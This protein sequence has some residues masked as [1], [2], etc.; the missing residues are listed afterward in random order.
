M[1]TIAKLV[2]ELVADVSGFTSNMNSA[3]GVMESVSAGTVAMGTVMGNVATGALEFIAGAAVG[4]ARGGFDIL[5]DSI[6]TAMSEA[7][8][9]QD[10][11][12]DL[13]AVL[14][15]TGAAAAQQAQ[16]WADAQGQMV[17]V[18]GLSQEMTNKLLLQQRQLENQIAGSTEG[19]AKMTAEYG[20]D[21]TVVMENALRLQVL[22]DQLAAVNQQLAD[23]TPRTVALTDALGLT[24]PTARMTRDELLAMAQNLRDL[25]GGSDDAVIGVEAILLRFD[26]IG[27]DTFPQATETALD[28]AAALKIDR[29]SAATLLGKVLQ[30]GEGL[31]VLKQAGVALTDQ[32][33]K[34][35]EHLFAVGKAAEA[36][37]IIMQALAGTIGGTAAEKADTLSGR[38]EILKNHLL[39]TAEGAGM[40]L[41]PLAEKLLTKG[42]PYLEKFAEG[43][44]GIFDSPQFVA[45]MDFA[46]KTMDKFF[47]LLGE[48]VSPVDAFR[49]TLISIAPPELAGTINSIFSTVQGGVAL[50][51][52]LASGD[53]SPLTNLIPPGIQEQIGPLATAVQGLFDAVIASGPQFAAAGAQIGSVFQTIVSL[54]GPQVLTN[55]TSGINALTGIW[56]NHGTTIIG[57]VTTLFNGILLTIGGFFTLATGIVSG[58]LTWI[59][60]IFDFYSQLLQGNW[61]G[62]FASLALATAQAF[63]T[64]LDS[65]NVFF[66][67]VAQAMGTNMDAIRATWANNWNMA[68][69]IVTTVWENIKNGVAAKVMEMSGDLQ[70]KIIGIINWLR[71]M[72]EQFL[73]IGIAWFEDMTKGILMKVTQLRDAVVSSIK[74]VLDA[75]RD[76]LDMH[77]PS[78]PLLEMGQMMPTSIAIGWDKG[79]P[80][81]LGRMEQLGQ[82]DMPAPNVRGVSQ[83]GNGGGPLGAATLNVDGRELAHAIFDYLEYE[84]GL[85]GYTFV[86][87]A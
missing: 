3:K 70:G 17:T 23:G 64:I 62:A 87:A 9:A 44:A 1:T 7:M 85:R 26:K 27:K 37:Q 52:Q 24:Q 71:G 30:T 2:A 15:A 76:A 74:D 80:G 69:L 84:G 29:N 83:A 13:D 48:G 34:Q 40:K 18:G 6:S 4:A 77:S 65:F 35:I 49:R 19:L 56:Q 61:R 21:N 22:K 33:Q 12:A 41:I 46:E 50:I 38:L 20:A 14:S 54:A 47:G 11:L 36:Q 59:G 73:Q 82:I 42:G 57:V 68:V 60:G 63:L 79:M 28:L 53:L 67:T 39:D 32:Q 43:L 78:K 55:I 10:T 81:L 16:A 45:G 31:R 5:K 66:E 51:Q 86:K 58:A 75:A 25:A 72:R 8:S